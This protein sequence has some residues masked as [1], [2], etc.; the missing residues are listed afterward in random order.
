M[1]LVRTGW[2]DAIG[3][4][5]AKTTVSAAA[6]ASADIDCNGA[7]NLHEVGVKVVVVFGGTPDGNVEVNFY[8]K[9]ADDANE[10]DTVPMAGSFTI[11]EV[12]SSEERRT[13]QLPTGALDTLV[14]EVVNN[15]SADN[16]TVWVEYLGVYF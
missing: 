7:N 2:T 4:D 16:V 1:P 15:D 3:T 9:D 5:G 12:A 10:Q 11:D 14:V 13:V 6:S 8:G